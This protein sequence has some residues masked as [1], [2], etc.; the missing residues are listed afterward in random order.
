MGNWGCSISKAG[1]ISGTQVGQETVALWASSD[2]ETFSTWSGQVVIH[3]LY[4][5]ENH[6]SNLNLS[7]LD[8]IEDLDREVFTKPD[9]QMTWVTDYIADCHSSRSGSFH[10]F[11]GSNE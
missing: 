3:L 5:A 8:L 7:Q 11:A 9:Q 10:Y 1:W 4:H 2:M 6:P